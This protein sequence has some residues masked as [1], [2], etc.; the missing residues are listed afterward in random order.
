MFPFWVL[1]ELKMVVVVVV[2]ARTVMHT[3]LQSNQHHQQTNAQ[4]LQAGC[5]SC[6]PTNTVKALK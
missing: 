5:P 6:C 3:K 2:T 4:F 1:L